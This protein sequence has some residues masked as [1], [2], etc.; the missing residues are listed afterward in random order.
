MSVNLCKIL[1]NEETLHKSNDFAS[2]EK[3][4]IEWKKKKKENQT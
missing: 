1:S 4:N 3:K 2:N